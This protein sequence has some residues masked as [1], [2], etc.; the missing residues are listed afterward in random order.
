MLWCIHIIHRFVKYLNKRSSA[1][2]LV[3]DDCPSRYAPPPN[4]TMLLLRDALEKTPSAN[5]DSSHNPWKFQKVR[6]FQN[7][8][9]LNSQPRQPQTG[10]ILFEYSY[11]IRVS[12][13][14][15]TK[16][17]EKKDTK[18]QVVQ[19]H[20]R[21]VSTLARADCHQC[22]CNRIHKFVG[23]LSSH[24]VRIK[25]RQQTQHLDDE[26]AQKQTS[27][28]SLIENSYGCGCI[29]LRTETHYDRPCN[30]HLCAV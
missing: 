12:D 17:S 27:T 15:K 13:P 16:T 10:Q 23:S 18:P 25:L 9:L 21:N 5:V 1:V 8:K 7:E 19:R 11:T 26:V 14:R 30:K 4:N 20:E 3:F 2:A 28:G 24:M 29:F 22:H 6:D